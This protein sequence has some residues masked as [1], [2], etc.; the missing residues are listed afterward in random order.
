ME[1]AAGAEGVREVLQA[2]AGAPMAAAFPSAAEARK[3][4]QKWIAQCPASGDPGKMSFKERIASCKSFQLACIRPGDPSKANHKVEH[5]G[6]AAHPKD[7]CAQPGLA[8]LA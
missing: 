1:V 3:R 4:R 7:S 6:D 5:S 8:S 2:W